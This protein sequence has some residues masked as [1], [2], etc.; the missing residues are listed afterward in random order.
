LIIFALPFRKGTIKTI[1]M[2]RIC[3]ISG[4]KAM[5][6][7][8]VSF[9]NKKNKRKFNV[10]LM[11]KKFFVPSKNEWITLRIS[12]SALKTIDKKGIEVVLSEAKANGN[13]LI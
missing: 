7:N 9:S 13:T 11:R 8:H 1:A 2:S 5:V 4:K 12:A 10:N 3:E 6:G